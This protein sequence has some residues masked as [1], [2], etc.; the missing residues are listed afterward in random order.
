[1]FTLFFSTNLL[2]KAPDI[3]QIQFEPVNDSNEVSS[4]FLTSLSLNS[5]NNE[6][7]SVVETAKQVTVRVMTDH[8][9]GSGALIAHHKNVYT[10]LTCKHVVFGAKSTQLKILTADG[11]IHVARWQRKTQFPDVDLAILQFSSEKAY[12]VVAL[13]DSQSL[14]AGDLVYAAGFFNWQWVNQDEIQD[15]HSWGLKAYQL[16]V[17]SVD[18]LP[19]HPLAEGYQIGYTNHIERG[20]S[21]GPVLNQYGELVG[22]N[23]RVSHPILGIAAFKFRD[24]TLPSQTA[25][26]QMEALSWAIPITAFQ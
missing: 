19:P 4:K 9:T 12:Q 14:L 1:M 22:I 15:T 23:G 21:G 2:L 7:A 16:T 11:T 10:V 6:S 8:A 5:P 3:A 25:F 13:G 26:K 18:L 20:M 24:G 17:G